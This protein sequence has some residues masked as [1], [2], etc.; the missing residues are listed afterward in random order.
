[1]IL[2]TLTKA[3][4]YAALHPLFPHAFEFMRS[5]NLLALAPGIHSIVGE[6]LFAIVHPEPLAPG[7]RAH[8]G[9]TLRQRFEY[10]QPGA[11]ADAQGGDEDP[12]ARDVWANIGHPANRRDPRLIA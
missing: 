1:M 11:A 4:R 3:D 7:C 9:D 6:Q 8:D 5:T 12:G 2:S 10:F